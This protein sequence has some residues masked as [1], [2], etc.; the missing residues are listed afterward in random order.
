MTSMPSVHLVPNGNSGIYPLQYEK[1]GDGP[2]LFLVHGWPFH[3]ASYRK[4]L[5]LLEPHFTCYNIRSAA[6]AD[7]SY[8]TS[9]DLSFSG[10]ANRIVELAK[11][12]ELDDI[13]VLAHDTGASIARMA[14]VKCPQRI[15]KLVLLNTEMPNHRPPFIPLYQKLMH[16]PIRRVMGAMFSFDFLLKSAMGYG[17]SFYDHRFL[18]KE[19]KT[20][21]IDHWMQDKSRFN[22]LAAYLTGLNF[23]D[24]DKLNEVHAKLQSPVLFIWGKEDKTFPASLGKE[25]AAG[26]PICQGFVE[27]DNACFLVHEEKPEIVAEHTI[28]FLLE[29]RG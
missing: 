4:I 23:S 16:L 3:S 15:K 13:A 6:L 14:A 21:F 1:S 26:I 18:D 10:H 17:E 9:T 11:H 2:A 7:N 8:D 28:N 12:L 24:I 29:T 25:M 20:L 22:G 19:F 5:P 27:V